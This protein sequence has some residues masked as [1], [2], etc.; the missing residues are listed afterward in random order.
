MSGEDTVVV[1]DAQQDKDE[2]TDD[3]IKPCALD[4]I[5]KKG[6]DYTHVRHV[7]ATD[8]QYELFCMLPGGDS[9]RDLILKSAGSN[10]LRDN[11]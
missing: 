2:F 1:S 6:R 3:E 8:E 5:K 10:L 9:I 4:S 7:F 11:K